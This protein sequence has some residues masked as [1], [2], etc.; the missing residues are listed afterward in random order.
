[1][2]SYMTPSDSGRSDEGMDPEAEGMG[3][4]FDYDMDDPDSTFDVEP[5]R[6]FAFDG[7]VGQLIADQQLEQLT[8]DR[9]QELV[10]MYD[11]EQSGMGGL[12]ATASSL[13]ADP[14]ILPPAPEGEKWKLI[15]PSE[16]GQG[17]DWESVP[18][19]AAPAAEKSTAVKDGFIELVK[20]HKVASA[21]TAA[22][23]IGALWWL[24]LRGREEE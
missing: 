12:G 20:K 23:T 2:Y 16:D 24:F 15:G 22:A 5:D 1:M 8:A 7:G 4:L 10:S 17:F 18:A 13:T 11:I 3:Q 21:V 9:A 19:D 6:P 14:S